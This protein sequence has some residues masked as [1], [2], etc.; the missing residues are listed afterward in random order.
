MISEA[1]ASQLNRLKQGGLKLL[2]EE[3]VR[4]I[5]HSI[6][7]YTLADPAAK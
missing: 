1:V 4:G 5:S 2:T 6:G 7:M 3:T